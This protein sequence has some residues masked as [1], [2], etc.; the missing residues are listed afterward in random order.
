MKR[1]SVQY[2]VLALVSLV[3]AFVLFASGRLMAYHWSEVLPG[4]PLE[5][6]TMVATRWGF[7]GPLLCAVASGIGAVVSWRRAQVLTD[8]WPRFTAIVA[9]EL[10]LVSLVSWSYPLPALHI[11]YRLGS[12][13]SAPSQ[14][15]APPE[16][17]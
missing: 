15:M 5:G 11:M 9:V 14:Q 17:P 6:L 1:A 7:V 2:L 13:N 8:T 4:E 3:V 10:L 12:V 16:H